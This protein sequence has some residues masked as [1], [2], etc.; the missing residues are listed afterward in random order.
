[1]KNLCP[2]DILEEDESQTSLGLF[3]RILEKPPAAVHSD[4]LSLTLS[5]YLQGFETT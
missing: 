3:I 4:V 5:T 2:G 1:M